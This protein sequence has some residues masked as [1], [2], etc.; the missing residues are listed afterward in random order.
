MT[1]VRTGFSPAGVA[2][3]LIRAYQKV[4]SPALGRNCRYQPTCSRYAYEAIGRFGLNLRNGTGP[5]FQH[6][7]RYVVAIRRK[8]ARHTELFA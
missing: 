4:L 8:Y 6:R 5:Y 1:D 2:Q 7:H 3:G